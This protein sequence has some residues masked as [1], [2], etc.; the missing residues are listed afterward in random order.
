M[1]P[2][3]VEAEFLLDRLAEDKGLACVSIVD[4]SE[5]S[6]EL[7]S[8]LD[9]AEET[10]VQLYVVLLSKEEDARLLQVIKVPQIRFYADG[11]EVKSHVG[12]PTLE[13]LKKMLTEFGDSLYSNSRSDD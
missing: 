9:K 13:A 3:F 4:T 8:H 1:K 5:A 12:T 11:N 6:M 7:L 2:D 10:D